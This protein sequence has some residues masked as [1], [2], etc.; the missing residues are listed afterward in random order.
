MIKVPAEPIMARA[1]DALGMALARTK[2]GVALSSRGYVRDPS[3]NLLDDIKL[4]DIE[5]DLRQ[6]DGNELEGKFRAAHSSAA[7][8]VNNF[9]PF[10][11]RPGSLNLAGITGLDAPQFERK[12]PTGLVGKPPNLDLVAENDNGIVAVESKCTEFLCQHIAEFRPAYAE[13]I[14]DERRS[15]PWFAEMMRLTEDQ[16]S[17]AWLDAA[18]LIKHA[19]GLARAFHGRK[20]ILLYL[21]WEPTNAS[22]FSVFDEHRREISDFSGRMLG[23][24][25][26]FR[27][28]SYGEL[29]KDWESGQ[30]PDWLRAHLQRVRAR[31]EIVI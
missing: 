30:P 14:H 12:C 27:A 16:T 28:M 25:P 21:F 3:E 4:E 13:R 11:L 15:G 8:V 23:G 2:P 19:F 5:A 18:Q 9:A 26:E 20:A 6:G 29:W 24:F 7:L 31:Y 22:S 1:I 10:K 17:Y